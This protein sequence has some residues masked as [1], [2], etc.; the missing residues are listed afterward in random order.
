MVLLQ[1]FQSDHHEGERIKISWSWRWTSGVRSFKSNIPPVDDELSWWRVV[2]QIETRRLPCICKTWRHGPY[3][4]CS[5]LRPI[6]VAAFSTFFALYAFDAHSSVLETSLCK[7]ESTSRASLSLS[8][9]LF[10]LFSHFHK[11]IGASAA[12]VSG[13]GFS[14]VLIDT[15]RDTASSM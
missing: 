3:I 13:H 12:I 7:A 10:Y 11:S 15:Y 1:L 6:L 14:T 2:V 8:P 5:F 4:P 9:H